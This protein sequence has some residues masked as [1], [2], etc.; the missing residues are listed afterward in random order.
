V[1]TGGDGRIFPKVARIGEDGLDPIGEEEFT[2][3]AQET[4]SEAPEAA[5]MMFS[6]LL[7]LGSSV[8]ERLNTWPLV[9]RG[10]ERVEGHV[11]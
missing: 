7:R 3:E 9:G 10:G 4:Q 2:T 6:C 11:V 8:S 5:R 1:Y